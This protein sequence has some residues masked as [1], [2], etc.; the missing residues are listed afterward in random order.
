MLTCVVNCQNKWA[1]RTF[2]NQIGTSLFFK[3]KLTGN[4]HWDKD[5]ATN[6]AEFI[7]CSSE[8]SPVFVPFIHTSKLE[9]PATPL[10]KYNGWGAGRGAD[11]RYLREIISKLPPFPPLLSIPISVLSIMIQKEPVWI[12]NMYSTQARKRAKYQ[13]RTNWNY[14]QLIISPLNW[15]ADFLD[16]GSNQPGIS[17]Q[18]ELGKVSGHETILIIIETNSFQRG[19][20]LHSGSIYPFIWSIIRTLRIGVRECRQAPK[21]CSWLQPWLPFVTA[22]LPPT[23]QQLPPPPVLTAPPRSL[24]APG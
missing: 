5:S 19:L 11:D 23:C 7:Y 17:C 12:S 13:K 20:S 18:P 9:K 6:P 10:F 16:S 15:D 24:I 2:L 3:E 1:S 14:N 21:G 22:C 8:W 4:C